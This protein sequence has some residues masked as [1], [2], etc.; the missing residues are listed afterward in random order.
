MN[1]LISC[2]TLIDGE[3]AQAKSDYGIAVED[4]KVTDVG[5]IEDVE[6]SHGEVDYD[7]SDNVVI[8]GLIDAHIHLLGNR[9]GSSE[10]F[11][12]GDTTRKSL[13]SLRDLQN[14]LTA[15]F[16]T[17]RDTGSAAGIHLRDAVEEGSIQ[18][19]RILAS[20][21]QICQTGSHIEGSVPREWVTD[22]PEGLYTLADGPQRCRVVARERGRNG[23]DLLKIFTSSSKYDPATQEF[24]DE[25]IQTFVEEAHRV[26]MHV[27]SHAIGPEGISA[28]VRNGVDTV[29]HGFYLHQDD[30]VVAAL[31]DS[32]SYLVPTL[33]ELHLTAAQ[34]VDHGVHELLCEKSADVLEHALESTRAAYREDVPIAM[35]TNI[36]GEE[37]LPHGENVLEAELYAEEV[38]MEPMDV[39]RSATSV[40]ADAI[41]APE[42]GRIRDGTFADFVVLDENPLRDISALRSVDAVF[43][44]GNC[45]SRDGELVREHLPSAFVN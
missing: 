33:A 37:H 10:K 4:G 23:Y 29:E 39:V 22:D 34:G 36:N 1:S 3:S 28:A 18:G 38:G 30:S 17:V 8:P 16:T 19:P 45:V 21:E 20:G 13:R 32:D 31:S 15:G 41:S 12:T 27:A 43:K 5:P 40:A 25:E 11:L 6:R 44:G 24:S 7:F 42:V 2:G 14:L 26:G 35:G 9:S